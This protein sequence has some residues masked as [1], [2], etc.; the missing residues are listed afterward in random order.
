MGK[1]I[2]EGEYVNGKRL[3]GIIRDY[4]SYG[5]LRYVSEY[6]NNE[7]SGKT[8]IYDKFGNIIFECEF[9]NGKS[10]KGF[11]KEFYL[12]NI[13]S[14]G[15]RNSEGKEYDKNGELIFVREF[16]NGKRKGI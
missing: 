10:W 6:S 9:Y 1:L 5:F 13:I 14:F 4:D 3:E 16:L 12:C 7:I 11:G 15:E 8:K 2:F